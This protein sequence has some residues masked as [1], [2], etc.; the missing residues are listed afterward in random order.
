MNRVLLLFLSGIVLA[1]SLVARPVEAQECVPSHKMLQLDARAR[2]GLSC[3]LPVNI[4]FNVYGHGGLKG[5]STATF[6]GTTTSNIVCDT[7]NGSGFPIAC[8]VS[9]EILNGAIVVTWHANGHRSNDVFDSS[10]N[11]EV[12][13]A[14]CGSAD[15]DLH[16]S[17]PQV[18]RLLDP[19]PDNQVGDVV[20]TD[21]CGCLGSVPVEQVGWGMIKATYR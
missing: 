4:T 19:Y 17:C 1:G 14:G 20:L 2:T 13:V 8:I 5:T 3:T 11:F 7:L 18:I 6:D 10:S 16:P 9:A 21:I 15:L 12:I